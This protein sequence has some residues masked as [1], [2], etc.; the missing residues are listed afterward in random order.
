[1]PLAD[2][3]GVVIGGL[4]HY[5]RDPINNYGQYY[6]EH[7]YVSTPGG[8]YHCAVDVDSE[9]T[10]DGIKW[11]V[12]PL[13]EGDMKGVASLANGWHDLASNSTS[14]AI[15]YIRTVAFH[16]PGCNIVFVRYDPFLEKLR[17][18][19]NWFIN[20]PWESGTSIEALAVLEPLLDETQKLFVFGEPFSYGGLGVHNVHQNQGD[21]A[22]SQWWDENGI[23]QDGGIIIQNN[24]G[25]YFAFLTK[26]KTQAN[27][28]D[29][30]GHPI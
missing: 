26:F 21:P 2:G 12:V 17:Q 20:P 9:K 16:R 11:R 23:W 1:M 8:G 28:T 6:H 3:Y 10:K 13:G 22:G 27:N 14:G 30:N 5:E 19:F 18:W 4:D 15:D 7:I 25:A 29:S 24:D